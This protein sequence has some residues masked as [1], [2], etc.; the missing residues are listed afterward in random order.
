MATN[1]QRSIT[2][3][4]ANFLIGLWNRTSIDIR[5]QLHNAVSCLQVQKN[6]EVNTKSTYEIAALILLAIKSAN[7]TDGRDTGNP[8]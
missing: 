3:D 2:G 7:S 5:K 6:I 4:S 1:V 8:V